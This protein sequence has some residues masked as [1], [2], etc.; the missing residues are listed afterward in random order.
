VYQFDVKT[1]FLN[2][3]LQEEVYVVQPPG[4]EIGGQEEKVYKLQKALYGLK[5][6]PRA[7][8]SRIDKFFIENGYERSLNEPTMYV[9]QSEKK[10][11]LVICIYV[12]DIIYTGSSQTLIKEF[13]KHMMEEFNMTDIGSLNYFRGFEVTQKMDGSF[14]SQKKYAKDL[15]DRFGMTRCKPANTP[16]NQSEKLKNDDGGSAVDEFMYRSL[17]GGLL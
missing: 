13:R 3:H 12:D 2:G 17:V 14:L 4:F 9:K 10:E 15:L 16:I 8:Y 6:A 1:A 7:W 5:Q 11:I